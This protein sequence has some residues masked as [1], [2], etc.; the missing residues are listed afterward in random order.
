MQ[1]P[2]TILKVG[3]RG[4]RDT[5][6]TLSIEANSHAV[7]RLEIESAAGTAGRAAREFP[8]T[9]ITEEIET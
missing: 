5:W 1:T 9:P 4:T 3:R 8:Q 6:K 7:K 2:E